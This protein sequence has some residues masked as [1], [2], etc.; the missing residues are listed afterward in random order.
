M[1]FNFSAQ[2]TV[3]EKA[4]EQIERRIT[5]AKEAAVQDAA[6]LAVQ[7]G[8]ADIADAGFSARWQDA[9][10]SIFY[11]NKETGDPAAL[12][13]HR[14][15]FAVVFERGVTIGGHPLLWLPIEA[16]LPPG[17]HSPR[18]FGRRL[19]SVN[20]AGKPPLLFDPA[21][22]TRGPLFFGTRSVTI[23]QR[24]HLHRIFERVAERLRD[25][26]EQKVKG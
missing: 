12:I 5:A 11:P 4:L 1:K 7:E 17:V 19:V 25:F 15:P 8:R 10:R 22:R 14:F 16:N 6:A 9:L 24:F 20:V 21:D 26:Y 2:E 23:R 3:F 13:F 18:E